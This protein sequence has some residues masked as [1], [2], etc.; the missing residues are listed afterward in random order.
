MLKK[1][2]LTVFI[3]SSPEF[4]EHLYDHYLNL[5]HVDCLSPLHL[6]LLLEFC[7]VLSF[8]T[9]SSFS[10]FCLIFCAYFYVLGRSVTFLNLREVA[11]CRRHL[12]GPGST[13]PSG[14]QIYM[15]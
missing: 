4:V 10:S 7:F 8:R 5:Y 14:Y 12:M 3:H 13:L 11:L 6:G 9:Y 1:K 2:I 15:L